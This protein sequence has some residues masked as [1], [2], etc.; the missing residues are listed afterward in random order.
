MNS[1]KQHQA[2]TR[3]F[4]VLLFSKLN[5][6]FLEYF[7]PENI[8]LDNENKKL[9]GDLTDIS[10]KKEALAGRPRTGSAAVLLF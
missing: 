5:E 8:Y 1:P 6:I 3:S 4:P 10:A 9:R 7:D 2:E